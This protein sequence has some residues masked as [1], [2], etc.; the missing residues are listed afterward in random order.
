MSAPATGPGDPDCRSLTRRHWLAGALAAVALG[1]RGGREPQAPPVPL[2]PPEADPLA[3]L[4]GDAAHYAALGT[5]T[6]IFTWDAGAAELGQACTEALVEGAD[7]VALSQAL[8]GAPRPPAPAVG[9]P[10]LA[11]AIRRELA[12]GQFQVVDGWVLAPTEVRLCALAYRLGCGTRVAPG[13]SSA[14]AP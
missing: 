6:C 10:A 14:R 8:F 12:A 2:P 3:G 11:E 5:E 7:P 4:A 1:C 9:L 13:G